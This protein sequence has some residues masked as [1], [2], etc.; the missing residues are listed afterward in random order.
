MQP[1]KK[2]KFLQE[3]VF[4]GIWPFSKFKSPAEV[5]LLLLI[6][7]IWGFVLF[8]I[9]EIPGSYIIAGSCGAFGLFLWTIGIFYYADSLRN[10]EIERINRV[11][12]KFLIEFLESIFHPSS[13]V[14]GVIC[15]TVVLTYFFT[16]ISFGLNN[17]LTQLQIEMNVPALP[18]LLLL[19]VFL[20]TFDICYRLSLSLYVILMQIRR[21]LRLAQYFKI[22]R[23][24]T[25]FSP[26]DIRNLEKADSI[27]YLAISG[28]F[29]LLPLG[30]MDSVILIAISSYLFCAFTLTSI[31]ILHLRFLYIKSIPNGLRYLIHTSNFAQVGT[32]S[33]DNS[34]HITPTLFVFDGRDFFISTSIKS[35]K[36]KNLRHSKKAALFIDSKKQKDITKRIGVLIIGRT[37]IYGHNLQT[38]MISFLFYGYRMVRVYFLFN[39]KYPYYIDQYR[40]MN[41]NLPRAWQI[42]PIISRTLIQ[43]TPEQLLLWKASRSNLT[44]I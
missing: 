7:F 20:L 40:K 9:Y 32:G 18:P 15:F 33:A 41:R 4:E 5:F 37:K 38:G 35:K 21:N 31:N 6:Y 2:Y 39:R 1:P 25:H 17:F 14:L 44:K 27:H 12:K 30:L 28:G 26:I 42:F 24:K 8:V 11:N 34:P 10:V 19:F 22:P 3:L 29:M 23:I 43:I 13:I 36:I 16:S